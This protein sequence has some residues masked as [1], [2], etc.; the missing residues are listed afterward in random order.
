MLTLNNRQVFLQQNDFLQE[1]T[2]NHNQAMWSK[3]KTYAS[4]KKQ[5]RENTF[6]RREEEVGRA[7]INGILPVGL[8]DQ[9]RIWELPLLASWLH[10]QWGFSLL[11]SIRSSDNHCRHTDC[12]YMYRPVMR[13]HYMLDTRTF[14]LRTH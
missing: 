6:N 4:S 7:I 9:H 12:G 11:I 2:K 8:W 13:T 14:I 1:Q 10:F 5:R 3:G